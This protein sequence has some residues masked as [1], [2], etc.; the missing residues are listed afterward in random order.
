M[1]VFNQLYINSLAGF[2]VPLSQIADIEFKPSPNYIQHYNK[3]RFTAVSAFVKSGYFP[4]KLISQIREELAKMPPPSGYSY[5]VAGEAESAER[6]FGGLGTIIVITV[7]GLLGVLILEFKSIRST[8]VVLSVIPLGIIG[9]VLALLATGYPFSFTVVVGLIALM[10]IE[11]KNSIL[12]V[13]F[14]NQLRAEGRGLDESILEA[15]EIRFVPILLT[16]MTA[17]GGLIPI[18]I[19]HN[20]LY[21]PLAWVLIGG[22]ISSTL[23]SRI[24]TPVLYKVLAPK[25]DRD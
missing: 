20:P 22:L 5:V 19:E 15:G 6:S 24:I 11:V 17:I 12:L 2:S 9:A 18:A 21:S 16:S 13:D 14:T 25:I 3:E 23:L 8:I 10:G 7:F 1:S 4:A